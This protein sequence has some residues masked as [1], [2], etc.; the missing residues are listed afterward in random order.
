MA[1]NSYIC[2]IKLVQSTLYRVALYDNYPTLFKIKY[3]IL[4]LQ[5][6]KRMKTPI[7][8]GFAIVTRH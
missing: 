1:T 8:Q 2:M 5:I 4:F 6:I 3:S 7:A